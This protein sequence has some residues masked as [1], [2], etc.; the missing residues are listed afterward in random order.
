MDDEVT[1]PTFCQREYRSAL[2]QFAT[3]VAIVTA[4]MPNGR[5]IGLTVNSFSSVSLDPPLVSWSLAIRA[6]CLPVFCAASHYAINVLGADQIGLSKSFASDRGDR[7][8][9]IDFELGAAGAPILPR[10]IAWFECASYSR[11]E[12]GDHI[13]FL[14]KVVRYAMKSRRP[15]LFYSGRYHSSELHV[16]ERR[17]ENA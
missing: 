10:C 3:G 1:A 15:L 4:T 12:A 9:A 2:G 16:L 11:H 8:A 17:Q 5:P 6:N 7:F 14:G 13:I